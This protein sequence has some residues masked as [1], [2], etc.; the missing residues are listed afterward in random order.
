M[1]NGTKLVTKTG[2][3]SDIGD[4]IKPGGFV[5]FGGGWSCRHSVLPQGSDVGRSGT[6]NLTIPRKTA[7]NRTS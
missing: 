6:A 1:S 7:R 3:L 4:I 5:T 2:K